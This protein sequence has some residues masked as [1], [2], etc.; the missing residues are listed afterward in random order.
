[1]TNMLHI[2]WQKSAST[3]L[4]QEISRQTPA[5]RH[6][7]YLVFKQHN[8]I[9]DVADADQKTRDT[10][11]RTVKRKLR[12][13]KLRLK[14]TKTP[15]HISDERISQWR[16]THA[17]RIVSEAT[18]YAYQELWADILHAVFPERKVLMICRKPDRWLRSLYAQDVKCGGAL[19][20]L[21]F[22]EWCE[23]NSEHA[24]AATNIDHLYQ[25]YAKRFGAENV[26]VLPYELF[27][28]EQQTIRDILSKEFALN[29]SEDFFQTHSN[30]SLPEYATEML[31]RIHLIIENMATGMQIPD[32]RKRQLRDHL[33]WFINHAAVTAD[34]F[35]PYMQEQ[36]PLLVKT[37]FPNA[38]LD[39]TELR[40]DY[41][42]PAELLT[43]MQ[44]NYA[45]VSGMPLFQTAGYGE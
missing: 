29:V 36:F 16:G 11:A 43:A 4:Q 20:H 14:L 39:M 19:C 40:I 35:T 25:I 42:V 34:N 6:I 38:K 27:S 1:M 45:R 23:G 41:T 21:P 5:S 7:N 15:F 31:R 33:F 37:A 8:P 3:L 2:G 44:K 12:A 30:A 17:S 13:H 9:L 24:L 26:V 22:T 32:D 18:T 28:S 10:V